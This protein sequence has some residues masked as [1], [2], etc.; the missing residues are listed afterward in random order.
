[1]YKQLL[2]DKIDIRMV[3]LVY[4]LYGWYTLELV[5]ELINPL[6]DIISISI[7]WYTKFKVYQIYCWYTCV[8]H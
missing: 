2:N 8:M 1:M 7:D 3:N 5:C 6:T 4:Q